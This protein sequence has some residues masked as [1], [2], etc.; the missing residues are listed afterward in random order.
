M[1][2]LKIAIEEETVITVPPSSSPT[3]IRVKL[4]EVRSAAAKLGWTAPREVV[5]DRECVHQRKV[6]AHG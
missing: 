6:A 2:A 4:I 1:L 5:I 3:E